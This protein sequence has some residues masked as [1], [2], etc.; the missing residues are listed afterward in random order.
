MSISIWDD[1]GKIKTRKH[2]YTDIISVKGEYSRANFSEIVRT[3]MKKDSMLLD[4][5]CG[6]ADHLIKYS[7]GA[8]RVIGIDSNKVSLSEAKHRTKNYDVIDIM[9]ADIEN[10]P[11]KDNDFD[12]ITNVF[13]QQNFASCIE[14]K[15]VLKDDGVYIRT[16]GAG[17]FV[18]FEGNVLTRPQDIVGRGAFVNKKTNETLE[19]EK[20]QIVCSGLILNNV[21]EFKGIKVFDRM[22]NLILHIEN[23]G[24][25]RFYEPFT[26]LNKREIEEL[27][28]HEKEFE[29][30]YKGKKM[31]AL[32]FDTL[33][34]ISKKK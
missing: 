17:D 31:F 26:S 9:C 30:S 14:A 20:Q 10:L 34:T 15:R 21:E 8:K 32:P 22:E 23:S 27:K 3:Y 19:D 28:K 11:F 4:E 16:T 25:F 33:L 7:N 29:I 5:G 24:H 18:E 6:I 1:Y 2:F 12:I 13:A